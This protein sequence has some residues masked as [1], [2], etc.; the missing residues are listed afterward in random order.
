MRVTPLLNVHRTEEQLKIANDEL[1]ALRLK[2][3][4]IEADRS[5][6]KTENC[7]LE[8]KVSK[9]LHKKIITFQAFITCASINTARDRES[10]NQRRKKKNIVKFALVKTNNKPL[11]WPV[12]RCV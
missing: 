4:K 1:L 3:E 6:L 11:G 12:A 8:S 10:N 2:V 7:R 5:T 9:S